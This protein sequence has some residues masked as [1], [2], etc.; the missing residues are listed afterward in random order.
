MAQLDV[1]CSLCDETASTNRALNQHLEDV[2]G[3]FQCVLC[4]ETSDS[5]EAHEQ[6]MME[7]H[8]C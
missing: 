5:I 2:H 1:E 4:D 3:C 6:H 7:V 8:N